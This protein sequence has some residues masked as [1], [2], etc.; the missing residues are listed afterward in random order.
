VAFSPIRLAALLGLVMAL[1]I[2][3]PAAAETPARQSTLVV[4]GNDPCPTSGAD[5]EVVVCARRPED[6]RYR[7]PRRIRE[8]QPTDTSWAS[9]AE[10]LD[11]ENRQMRP[12]SCSVVGSNGFTGCTSAMIRQWYAERR[13]RRAEDA[14]IP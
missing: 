7:I 2:F 13:Q 9:R 4:Y 10:G 11:E 3:A 12:N 8:R 6:E 14:N 5:N 1:P